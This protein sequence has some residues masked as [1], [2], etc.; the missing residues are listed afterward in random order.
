MQQIPS[1]W[2]YFGIRNCW[3]IDGIGCKYDENAI[4][5]NTVWELIDIRLA[6]RGR[7]TVKGEGSFPRYKTNPE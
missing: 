1:P 4:N 7:E 2:T 3:Q 6:G 5:H